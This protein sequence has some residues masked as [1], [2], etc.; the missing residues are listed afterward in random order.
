MAN[1][2]SENNLYDFIEY[3]LP[4]FDEILANNQKPL[5]QRPLAATFY[6]VDYCIV[7]IKGD[8][9]DN[10]LEKKW[11]KSIYKLIKKWYTNR[12]AEAMDHVR[13]DFTLGV[14][15]IYDTPF[16][17]K[18]PL[19]VAEEKESD[20]K[21]WFCLLSSILDRENVFEWIK[22]KPN[23]NHMPNED[24]ESLKKEVCGIA[25]SAR[26]IN[27]NLMSASLDKELHKISGSIP[28]HIDK[29]VRDI[30]SLEGGRISTSFWEIHL[31][32]EK[33]IKLIILQNGRDHNNSHNLSKICKIANNIKGISIDC[34]I[35]SKFPSGNEAI[36]QRYGEGKSFTVQEAVNNYIYANGAIA[37]LTE[38]LKRKFI[39]NNA[40]FLIAIPPWEK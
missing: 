3:Q 5:S 37:K 4:I 36:K 20:D 6:F 22:N 38:L 19:S 34:D 7:D 39:M 18:I 13:D 8:N 30:L 23:F 9:K 31:A 25:T 26:E 14:V 24:I 21:R 33:T 2:S 15:L 10:F 27:V 35:L 32:I 1:K 12:Y 17:L 40:R 29:A 16:Q 28:A 11:F